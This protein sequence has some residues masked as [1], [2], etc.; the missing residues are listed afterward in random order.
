MPVNPKFVEEFFVES[1][2]PDWQCPTCMLGVLEVDA[3][4]FTQ[5]LDSPSQKLN[6]DPDPSSAMWELDL[7]GVFNGILTCSNPRCSENVAIS[8]HFKYIEANTTFGPDDFEGGYQAVRVLI[9]KYFTPSLKLVRLNNEVPTDIKVLMKQA[10]E[11]FWLDESSCGNKMRVLVEKLMDAQAVASGSSLHQRL[12]SYK[13]V[14]PVLADMLMAVKWLGNSGSHKSDSLN[15]E[16]LITAADIL[17]SVL[18]TV[19]QPDVT[20]LIAKSAAINAAK[21]PVR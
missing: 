20:A 8:G 21:G 17:E 15:R 10:L 1:N 2:T 18:N 19:Y 3:L 11:L 14:Q 9:P 7:K 6:D 16:D 4:G 13:A 5:K 12:V